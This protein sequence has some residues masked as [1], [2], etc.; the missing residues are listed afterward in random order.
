MG[1]RGSFRPPNHGLSIRLTI[2]L[3]SYCAYCEIPKGL[4]PLVGEERLTRTLHTSWGD[5]SP[6]GLEWAGVCKQ[7]VLGGYRPL[8]KALSPLDPTIDLDYFSDFAQ[9]RFIE[10]GTLPAGITAQKK[11]LWA[12][13]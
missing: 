7:A 2:N 11:L 9:A 4:S 13:S 6:W 3:L 12:V 5:L 8:S 10:A 1:N